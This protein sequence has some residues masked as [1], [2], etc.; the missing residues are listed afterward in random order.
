MKE[1]LNNM[2]LEDKGRLAEEMG[3]SEDFQLAW[4]GRHWSSN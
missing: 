4:L 3:A 2:S 1:Q